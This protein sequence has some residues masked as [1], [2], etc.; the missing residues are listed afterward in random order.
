[1]IYP[2]PDFRPTLP[3]ATG[4]RYLLSNERES[5]MKLWYQSMSRQ[6]EWGGYPAVLRSILAKVK[7]EGTEIHVA[8]I[9]DIGG[10]GDQYRYLEYLETGEVLRNVHTAVREGYDAFLIGNIADPGLR[11]ARE[12][13]NIPVLGLCESAMH[14]ACM[15]GANFSF[16]TINEKFTPR[17]VENV[18]RYGLRARFVGA[19]RMK[20][21]RITD[22][23]PGF[24]PGPV[25]DE[26]VRQFNAAAKV[27]T[28]N[29]AEVVI[30]AGGVVMAMLAHAGIHAT[31]DGVPILNGITNLVKLGEAAVKMDRIMGGRFVSKKCVYAPPPENQ[32]EA[33]RKHYGADIYPTVKAP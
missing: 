5:P 19:S 32:I 23:G 11:E 17:V 1:M 13:A 30:A 22:L 27:N 21:D 26:I 31:E 18:D 25:Q 16:V 33:F 24:T 15:M 3:S 2:F 9:T 14:M 20:I 28:E 7:D 8:G 6:E 10:I 12:I 29:G 4:P